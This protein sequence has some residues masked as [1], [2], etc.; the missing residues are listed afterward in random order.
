MGDEKKMLGEKKSVAVHSKYT[1]VV[2]SLCDQ[3]LLNCE[4]KRM[5][6]GVDENWE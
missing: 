1:P 6:V 4:E 5:G 2:K 3:N